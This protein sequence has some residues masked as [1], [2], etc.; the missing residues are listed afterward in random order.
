[1]EKHELSDSTAEIE[2]VLRTSSERPLLRQTKRWTSV[3]QGLAW[4]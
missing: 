4:G 3:S 1:M 2:P